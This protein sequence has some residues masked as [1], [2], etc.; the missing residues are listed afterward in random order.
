MN[1]KTKKMTTTAMLC[2][3]AYVIVVA[4]HSLPI[5]VMAA[6]PFLKYDPKDI[7]IVLGGLIW[8]PGTAA[9]VS[10]IVSLIEMVTVSTTGIIGAIMN[11]ISTC[12]FSCTAAYIYKKK[13]TLAGA[14][15]GLG[16]GVVTM[17]VVMLLWNY[18]ITPLYMK[19]T[20]E[21]VAGMLLTVFLPFNLIKG[22]LN[23]SATFLLYKPIVTA[24]RKA[25][26]VESESTN[27]GRKVPVG[28]ILVALGILISCILFIMSQ[29][30]II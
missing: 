6:A 15:V 20:R 3:I 10:L 14:V 7:V 25:G 23:A 2:A 28:L 4:M 17:A 19:I 8:G 13:H 24:L 29:N 26:L 16:V 11:F 12:A 9:V 22:S 1:N 30:G 5:P 21:Q 18:L 27:K